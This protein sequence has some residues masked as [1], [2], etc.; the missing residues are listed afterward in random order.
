MTIQP[1]PTPPNA[2][3]PSYPVKKS[4]QPLTR[5]IRF[6]DGYE[7]RIIFGIPE[8]QNPKVF[9]FVWKNITE[10]ESDIIE[11]FLDSR[12]LD[13]ES[14]TY[15]PHNESSSMHFKCPKWNKNMDIPNRATITAT[16]TQ[17]FEPS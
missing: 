14:F 9:T 5:T 11:N 3:D 4:S 13:G 12:A 10:A 1:F 17:V 16:F 2:P 15:T 7:H 6:A 8:H